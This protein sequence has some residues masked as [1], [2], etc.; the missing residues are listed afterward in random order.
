MSGVAVIDGDQGH[1]FNKGS[2]VARKI[3][4]WIRMEISNSQH[5]GCT[6]AHKE[7]NVDN[8]YVNLQRSETG[9][10]PLSQSLVS[11]R[12]GSEPVRP[13]N[14]EHPQDPGGAHGAHPGGARGA[15]DD[16]LREDAADG[17]EI[18]IRVPRLPPEHGARQIAK[19]ELTG[20]G[21]Y[22]SWCRFC[23]ASIGSS[24]RSSFPR[25][26]RVTQK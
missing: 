24:A 16:P 7:D 26:R 4:A 18:T 10:M 23:S 25:G 19:H 11:F 8:T 13:E 2:N 12:Q 21:V 1:L 14:S 15:H 5:H 3:E 9:A 17:E 22:R 20:H 6:V